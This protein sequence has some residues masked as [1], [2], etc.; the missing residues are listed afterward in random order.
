MAFAL[1]GCRDAAPGP[2]AA[3]SAVPQ[4]IVSVTLATD[5]LLADLVPPERVVG[6]TRFADDPAV[7]NVAGRYPP[8]VA[9]I[10]AEVEALAALRPDL[11]CV[12]P[13]N[14][15]DFLKLLERCGLP[16][17]RNEDVRSFAG[18]R[19]GLLRLGQRLGVSETAQKLAS[20]FDRRLAA[21]HE[22]LKGL[23]RRPRVLYWSAGYAAGRDTVVGEMIERAGGVNV[24]AE[25][26]LEDVVPIGAER[27]VQ[28]DP[29]VLL[30]VRAGEGL[31]PLA[32]QPALAA[33]R[34]VR[35][36]QVIALDNRFLTTVSHH[37]A[38]GVERLATRLHPDRFPEG[39][40]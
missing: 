27:L 19:Q 29:D 39:P 36:R 37:A 26:G 17:Y 10:R 24:G 7:S 14:S 31:D 9:R 21:V 33:L 18:I 12:A 25:L 38:A 8:A 23:E 28:A 30:V 34:A 40:R 2:S 5:E 32:G 3:G 15:A 16:T 20:E 11:V 22:R 4:R 35:G 6:V 1:A 13:Y